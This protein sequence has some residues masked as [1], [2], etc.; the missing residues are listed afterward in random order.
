[1][2]EEVVLVVEPEGDEVSPAPQPT[3]NA[4]QS[5]IVKATR[6]EVEGE[7]AE[8]AAEAYRM[9]PRVSGHAFLAPLMPAPF[10][11]QCLLARASGLVPVAPSYPALDH[12]PEGEGA[13]SDTTGPRT[14]VGGRNG[15]SRGL[16][17][18]ATPPDAEGA[19]SRPRGSGGELLTAPDVAALLAVTPSWV[20]A[21]TRAGRIPAVR[22][23]RYYRYRR[24]AVDA[25]V[26]TLESPPA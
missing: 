11:V 8:P 19:S 17:S 18:P 15:L 7:P 24:A 16:A 12:T 5:A 14:A 1:M 21:Q 25:W 10:S 20:Y 9:N 6:R 22:L 2:P 13:G 23:G 3:W 26:E 4:A